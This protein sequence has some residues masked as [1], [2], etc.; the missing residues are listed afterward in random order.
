M[1]LALILLEMRVL[2]MTISYLGL[3]RWFFV[4][5]IGASGDKEKSDECGTIYFVCAEFE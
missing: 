4:T 5:E 2:N 1:V 3:S